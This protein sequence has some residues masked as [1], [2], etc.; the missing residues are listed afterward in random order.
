MK[1]K[2]KKDRM[3]LSL[4]MELVLDG[5]RKGSS[6]K[7]AMNKFKTIFDWLL[8]GMVTED[9]FYMLHGQW[10]NHSSIYQTDPELSANDFGEK[11][12]IKLLSKYSDHQLDILLGIL[13]NHHNIR[14][15]KEW[16]RS[17][18]WIKAVEQ[19]FF[20]LDSESQ[21]VLSVEEIMILVLVVMGDSIK[22][23]SPEEILAQTFEFMSEA[24]SFKGAISLLRFKQYFHSN[25]L[26][27]DSIET[28]ISILEEE[29][30]KMSPFSKKTRNGRYL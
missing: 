18:E 29:T 10:V 7:E 28:S 11:E 26:E 27:L 17:D 24:K 20:M 1:A 2:M 21:T 12:W 5:S 16:K 13:I 9:E 30:W 6:S 4:Y 15:K 23:A 3:V 14:I 8:N 22:Q 25:K 19:L